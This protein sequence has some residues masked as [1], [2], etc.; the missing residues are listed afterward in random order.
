MVSIIEVKDTD[1]QDGA[2]IDLAKILDLLTPNEHR[3]FWTILDLE[4]TG[5]LG[6]GRNMLDLEEEI[7]QS[8]SGLHVSWDELVS[9]AHTFLQVI[10]AVIVGYNRADSVPTL[11]SRSNLYRSNEIVLEMIDSTVWRISA[12]DDGLIQKL[13]TAL[14]EVEGI[15]EFT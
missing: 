13:Q 1:A 8:P 5:E 6:D 12:K 10:N 7:E 14:R 15:T 3:L 11:E 2:V 9:L 4:A